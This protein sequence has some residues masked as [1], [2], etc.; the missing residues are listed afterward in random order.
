[1]RERRRRA[2][3][4]VGTVAVVVLSASCAFRPRSD[5]SRF[6]VLAASAPASP[7]APGSPTVGLGPITMPG[8]LQQPMLATRVD[9][10]QL[11]YAEFDRWAEPLP[12]LFGRALGGDLSTALRARVVAYPWYRTTALDV[13]VLVDVS[14]FEVD[15]AGDARLEACWSIRDPRTRAVQAGD[16]STITEAVDERGARAD[17]AALGRAVGELARQVASA[18]RP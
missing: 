12:T 4:A 10:T 1:M 2:R 8:Y 6:Y 15:G 3:R 14:S 5:P 11:R 9:G 18:I 7:P 16:C 17:V 13:V